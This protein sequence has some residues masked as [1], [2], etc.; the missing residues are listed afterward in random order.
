V[1]EDELELASRIRTELGKL[2]PSYMI[3]RKII[4]REHIPMTNNGKANRKELLG[5]VTA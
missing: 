5:E 1:P 4:F 3:P 2:I